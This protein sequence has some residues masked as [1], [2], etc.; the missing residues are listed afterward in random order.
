M[1]FTVT[2]KRDEYEE[3]KSK[4]LA[5]SRFAEFLKKYLSRSGFTSEMAADLDEFELQQ[6][7]RSFCQVIMF[8]LETRLGADFSEINSNDFRYDM[9]EEIGYDPYKYAISEGE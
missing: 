8:T 5:D 1:D 3:L 9:L 6:D 2:C 4:A 7:W